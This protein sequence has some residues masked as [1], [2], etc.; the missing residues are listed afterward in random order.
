ME[1]RQVDQN[2]ER[3]TMKVTL[4]KAGL[5]KS[6]QAPFE[7]HCMCDHCGATARIAFVAHEGLVA[8]EMGLGFASCGCG[9]H[10]TTGKEG[11]LW[12]HDLC[13]VAVYFCT[14]CLKPTAKA[15]QA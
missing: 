10:T 4:G 13:T 6:W 8:D 3:E 9:L 14:T 2:Q 1:E 7:E 11:D 12:V 15:N 5:V